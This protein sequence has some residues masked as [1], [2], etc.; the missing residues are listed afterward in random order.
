MKNWWYYHKWYV[1][2]AI[3]LLG[4]LI[5][6]IGNAFHLFEKT[7]DLQIAYIGKTQLSQETVSALEQAFSSFAKDFN[8]D[9]EVLVKVNQYLDYSQ[10][11]ENDASYYQSASEVNLIG[12][13]SDCESYFFIME[14]PENF[15]RE[16]HILASPD[17][18]C[19]GDLDYSISDKVI[20]L[21]DC[22]TLSSIHTDIDLY[23]G[24]RCFY[25]D[26]TTDYSEQCSN[27]WDLLISNQ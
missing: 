20:L 21:S 12:D 17:G 1:I 10:S 2:C 5:H 18:S 23:L 11:I 6:M 3:I 19:P 7:P 4:S 15:Q 26:K 16:Y 9:G 13:I 25:T 22:D 14:E 8:G 27:L 24:R